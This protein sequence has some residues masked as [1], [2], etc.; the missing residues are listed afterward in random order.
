MISSLTRLFQPRSKASFEDSLLAHRLEIFRD[1]KIDCILDVGANTGQYATSVLSG[2]SCRIISFEPMK[3]EFD[4]LSQKLSRYP[5]WTAHNIGLGDREERVN[6][7][8]SENS[9]SSSILGLNQETIL[10]DDSIGFIG[11]QVI[12]VKRLDAIWD[13]LPVFGK[14]VLLKIDTQGYENRVLNGSSGVLS[15]IYGIQVELS[16]V[17]LYREEPL[18][19]EMLHKIQQLGFDLYMIEP[20]YK[21]PHSGK[22]L[23]LEAIFFRTNV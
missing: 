5:Y 20:G 23:Q 16:I 3:K 6:I 13:T 1:K 2:Y 18:F 17:Q 7:N 21:D 15:L 22:L 12:Q 4:E 9:F 11:T 19:D 8:I 14:R 10:Y